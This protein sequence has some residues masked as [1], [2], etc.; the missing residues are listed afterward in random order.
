[1][2]KDRLYLLKKDFQDQGKTY[3][4]PG[5]VELVGLLEFY[6]ELKRHIDVYYIDFPRPRPDLAP[7]LGEENQ[8][9]PVL[10]LANRPGDLPKHLKVQTANGHSFVADARAIGEYLAHVHH[11]GLPH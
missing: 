10:V 8:G 9:S 11:I 2:Q 5:C 1:M 6:P 7:L 3:Y 4:C